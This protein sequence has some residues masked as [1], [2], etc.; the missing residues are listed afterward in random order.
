MPLILPGN[1]ASATAST[2]YTVANSC[3]FNDGDSAYMHKTPGSSGNMKTWTWNAWIKRGSMGASQWLMDAYGGSSDETHLYLSG[4]NA[5]GFY[6][7]GTGMGSNKTISSNNLLRDPSAW[8]MITLRVDTTDATENNRC[9]LYINGT[10]VSY[11]NHD[12]L[13]ED[14]DGA[15]NEDVIQYLGRRNAGDYFDG[16]M[17]EVCLVD[18]SSLAPTSFGEFDEDSPTI[19]KP[20]D[21]S[22]LSFGTNGYYLDFEAS[23]N[24]GNDANGGTDLTEANLDA[25]DQ[26]TDTPT[27]NFCTLNP[28]LKG[29]GTI[30]E[31]NLGWAGDSN[32]RTALSTIAVSKGKWYAE[33]KWS[34]GD[35]K[36]IG[37]NGI[38]TA[39]QATDTTDA[40]GNSTPSI[41]HPQS[42]VKFINGASTS[43]GDAYDGTSGLIIGVA[44]DLDNHNLY[45]SHNNTWQN[46]GDPESGATGTGAITIAT[47]DTSYVFGCSDYNGLEYANFGSPPYANSSDAADANGYGAFE[48]APPSGYYALCTKNLAEFG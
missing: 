29:G 25:T 32:W 34:S 22:G 7:T 8:Y 23:D 35:Y 33:F 17:A 13:T 39:S 3:R 30:S 20:I 14:G 41:S 1:V 4:G 2:T 21:V 47:T 15:V 45:F 38:D 46:S 6:T 26:A 28:L 44:M 42:G 12:A 31:G 9:R 16:Y 11:A 36:Y 27:N 10:E 48:Y 24:L 5:L 40:I 37:I 19:W 43:Y 18:G